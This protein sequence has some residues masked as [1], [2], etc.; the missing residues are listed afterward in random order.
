VLEC[1]KSESIPGTRKTLNYDFC[2]VG[3]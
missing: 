1:Y 2:I 3:N